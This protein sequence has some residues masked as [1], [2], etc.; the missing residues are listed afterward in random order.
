MAGET[1]GGGPRE[2]GIPDLATRAWEKQSTSSQGRAAGSE[3]TGVRGPGRSLPGRDG[4]MRFHLHGMEAW[5]RLLRH[6]VEGHCAMPGK[7]SDHA[8]R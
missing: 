5:F 8:L 3:S 7:N 2:S 1:G 4:G 6:A